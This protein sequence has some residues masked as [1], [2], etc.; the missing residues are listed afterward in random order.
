M[1]DLITFSSSILQGPTRVVGFRGVEA[2]SRPYRFEIF[3]SVPSEGEDDT[4]F[5]E[6]V[7]AKARLSIDRQDDTNPPYVFTGVLAGVD[8]VHEFGGRALLRAVLVP[9]LWGLTLSKHSRIFT[10]KTVP[11][12]IKLVLEENGITGSD[13]ELNLGSYE[14]EEH[15]CQYRESDFDFVS[16]WM[17]REGI[18]YYFEHTE[19]GEKLVL[20]D[21]KSYPAGPLAAP[22]RYHPQTGED[23]SAS[24]SFRT[25]S[26]QH[27]ALPSRVKLK[28]YDYVR[29]HFPL[30]GSAPV[31]QYGTGEIS[32]HGERFFSADAGKRLAQLRAEEYLAREAVYQAT[33]ARL[34]LRS[35]YTF[36]LEDHPRAR[37]NTK[38]LAVEL[39]HHG[40]QSAG[41]GDFEELAGLT[42]E[43][44]YFVE[45]A[46]IPAS[47]QFRAESRTPWPRIY[48]YEN[49]TVDGSAASE[50]AQIDEHG[51][52]LVK[53]KFDEASPR[54][55]SGSTYVRM[56]QP[57]GGG[58][59]G[60][61]FPLRR[62]TEVLL[63]FL[64]GD[65][66]RPVISGVVPNVLTPS[67]VT[68]GNH[69][70]NVIQTGGRNRLEL[71]DQAGAQRITLSTPYSNTYMRM[72][73]PNHGH[74]FIGKTDGRILLDAGQNM[75]FL[76]GA[77]WTSNVEND[78]TTTAKSG[79]ITTTATAGNITTTATAGTLTETAKGDVTITSTTGKVVVKALGNDV[80]ISAKGKLFLEAEGDKKEILK[81]NHHIQRTGDFSV[82]TLGSA[83]AHVFGASSSTVVG[84]SLDAKLGAFRSI[85]VGATN[86]FK[87]TNATSLTLGKSFDLKGGNFTSVNVSKSLDIKLASTTELKAT[88]AQEFT[89]G[90]KQSFS[91]S[92]NMEITAGQKMS[93]N[94]TNTVDFKLGATVTAKNGPELTIQGP[95]FTTKTVELK[96]GSFT[97]ESVAAEIRKHGIFV[98]S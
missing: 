77:S 19:D 32:L 22:V 49:G 48:G 17:E 86:D 58:V 78:I 29:P 35:G 56:M 12:V 64:G 82:T 2:I 96:N 97:L 14:T 87:L 51:R 65:P 67:P 13:V 88:S 55:G 72:G 95:K 36:E 98:V 76:V 11:E 93:F 70:K 24:A 20:C 3:L 69:T 33:G 5:A 66:D 79:N 71:E 27:G 62:G 39:R 31:S 61:H 25:F 43:E 50:Y 52:Y 90:S 84:T 75:D 8:L 53:F 21:D 81:S 46:A 44:V 28:D 42:H 18:F 60:F 26:C 40:N 47:T 41:H 34:H 89:I 15:I 80:E 74:E 85:V 94:L 54:D 30:A 16:R 59:E 37:F 1:S 10:K 38:Y 9:R 83:R 57:H 91:L 7:G 23:R 68:S 73:S 45:V 63:S 4:D 6:M 92:R